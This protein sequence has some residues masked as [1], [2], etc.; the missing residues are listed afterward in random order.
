MVFFYLD[1][2]A[3]AGAVPN[4]YGSS[5][6]DAYRSSLYTCVLDNGLPGGGDV[7]DLVLRKRFDHRQYSSRR[8]DTTG[9]EPNTH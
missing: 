2:T 8:R 4:I 9:H 1:G 6:S 3:L 5:D 7:N